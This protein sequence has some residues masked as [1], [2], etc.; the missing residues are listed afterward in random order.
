MTS[1]TR[2]ATAADAEATTREPVGASSVERREAAA[3]S[4][5]SAPSVER[6]EPRADSRKPSAADRPS[7]LRDPALARSPLTTT[8]GTPAGVVHLVAELAPYAR[9]GGLGE[10]VASLAAFQAASGM[11]TAVIMPLYRQVR[12]K[13][14]ALEPVGDPF[15]VHVGFRAE[16]A[17][18]FRVAPYQPT[19]EAPERR[20]VPRPAIYFIH[21]AHYFDRPGIYGEGGDYPDNARRFAFF[22]AAALAALPR[23]ATGPLILHSHDWHTALATIYLRTWYAGHPYHQEVST[24]LSVHNAGYQ[25]HFSPQTMAEVGLPWELYN[26]DQLEWYGKVNLLKGGMAFADAVTTVSR[27]HANELR[28]PGGGF[29]LHDAFLALRDRFVGIVNGIDQRIWDPETDPHIAANYSAADPQKKAVCRAALQRGYGLPV[30]DGIPIFGMSARLVA[31]K[32]LDLILAETG[33][34]GLDAQF[35]FLG[36]GERRY[37]EALGRAAR[38]WPDKLRVDTAFRDVK[39]H[40]LMA[41][42]DILLMPCQYEPCGLTQMRAQR[43]GMLPLA[44]CV[45]GLADTVEDGVTGFLFDEYDAG[46]FARAAARA[47]RQYH[48][49]AGWA[50]MVREAMSRDFAWERSEERYFSVYRGVLAAGWPHR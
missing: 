47:V 46:S 26:V 50:R 45:G 42:G 29:G 20:R 19:P 40:H 30:R 48:D 15:V 34:F 11:P 32:G 2:S 13:G 39:E 28:T 31:Q 4:A 43:Y 8:D 23:V 5:P 37:E 12:N 35:I 21:N 44:R 38:R 14:V 16:Q 9:T 25:G 6:R 17:Q 10:A 36:A 27:S 49:R 41:G 33:F 1:A 3:P 7:T 18:L 24:V 22:C